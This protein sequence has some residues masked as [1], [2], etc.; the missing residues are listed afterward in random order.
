MGTVGHV[1]PDDD[2]G[3]AFRCED[4]SSDDRAAFAA[5]LTTQA[6]AVLAWVSDPAYAPDD[7][8]L[9][10]PYC[11]G[12]SDIDSRDAGCVRTGGDGLFHRLDIGRFMHGNSH[13]DDEDYMGISLRAFVP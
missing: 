13:Q 8:A 3:L 5:T 6:E 4:A 7:H 11:D 9:T 10:W 1:N 12:D 2:F